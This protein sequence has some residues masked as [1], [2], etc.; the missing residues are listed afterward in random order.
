ME[1]YLDRSRE[2]KRHP[3][4]YNLE[5]FGLSPEQVRGRMG[6]YI[7]RFNV[8]MEKPLGSRARRRA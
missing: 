6:D 2:L 5:M 1:D 7:D 3:H 8:P 4:N